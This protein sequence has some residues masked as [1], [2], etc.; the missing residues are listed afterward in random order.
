MF[1]LAGLTLLFV[2]TVKLADDAGSSPVAW[3]ALEIVLSLLA[4]ANFPHPIARV[5]VPAAVVLLLLGLW[6]LAFPPPRRRRL[7]PG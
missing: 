5:L 4:F 7:P 1:E 2:I 6:R 3:G